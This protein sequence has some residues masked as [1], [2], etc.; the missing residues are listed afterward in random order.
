MYD[1]LRKNDLNLFQDIL[2]QS[3]IEKKKYASGITNKKID[4]I[5]KKAFS[6]GAGAMKV[7]GAGGGGH[8]YVYAEK[9]KHKSIIRNMAKIGVKNIEFRFTEDGAKVVD[10]GD[11]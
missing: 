10:V 3:W 1:A 4:L 11:I 8:L 7:T 2:K 6:L 9:S 5:I